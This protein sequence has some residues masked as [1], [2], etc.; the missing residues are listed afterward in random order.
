MSTGKTERLQGPEGIMR[1]AEILRRGGTV[2]F[3]TETVYGL[4]ANAI[5]ATAVAKIFAAKERPGWDPVIVHVCDREMGDR[6]AEVSKSAERLMEVF[7]PGPLTL[8]L[9]RKAVVPD[10]VTAGR[11]LVGVRMPRHELALALI[12]EAGIPVAA[13]SANRFGRTS[14]TT[15]VHVLG[16]LEGRIDAV[17]DGGPTEVGVESTVIGPAEDGPHWV[18]YR[19]GGVSKEALE[20]ALGTGEVE[21]FRPADSSRTPESLPSP[22]VGIRHYAPRARLVL[23]QAEGLD[24][25]VERVAEGGARAGVMLPDGYV[26]SSASAIYPW[27]AWSDGETLARRLFAG[28]R[29]LDEAGVEVIV[30]PVPEMSGIGEAI[31]D[32]LRKAAREK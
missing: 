22:G 11:P 25:A 21:M 32:R 19:P 5:D 18:M 26:V 14:P 15:A 27:G 3:P 30:C 4:G 17:L 8:L 9:P 12:R 1:A 2:A 10:T 20:A 29:E 31:R 23:V 28:L 24:V 16:D 6:V 7:W 13:P